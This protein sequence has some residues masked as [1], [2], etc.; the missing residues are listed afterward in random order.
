MLSSV[1]RLPCSLFQL[2][3]FVY[4]TLV[5]VFLTARRFGY[6]F[7]WNSKSISR[8]H[9]HELEAS[10]LSNDHARSQ[11]IAKQPETYITGP[12][13]NP[14]Q[15]TVTLPPP[16]N[17][18]ARVNAGFIVLVRNSELYG[19]LQSMYDVGRWIVLPSFW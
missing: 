15:Y 10:S 3:V 12:R 5:I 13:Y 6:Q 7:P 14:N 2:T 9:Q 19:M 11:Y 1:R 18:T 8:Q 4:F 16:G 17:H